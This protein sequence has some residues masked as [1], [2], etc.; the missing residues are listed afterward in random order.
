MVNFFSLVKHHKPVFMG[1]V[2]ITPD[3]FS[4]G[5]LLTQQDNI[6]HHIDALLQAGTNI[7][8]IGAESTRPNS[9]PIDADT[10]IQ[11]LSILNLPLRQSETCY[12]SIDTYKAQT[13]EFALKNGFHIVNDVTGL[14]YDPDMVKVVADYQAG[15]IIMHNQSRIINSTGNIV[16]D[17]YN[18][19]SQSLE[20]ALGHHIAESKICLD[21]GIGFGVTPQQ[22]IELLN[23]ISKFKSLGFPIMV[24][25][26]RKSFIKH[27]LHIDNPQKRLGATIATH[28]YACQQGADIIRVHDVDDH[29][30]FF[31]MLKICNHSSHELCDVG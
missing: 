21:I 31:D 26:S 10:E 20:I 30:Q 28:Y 24:G 2:N 27:Y 17:V 16:T 8:D 22:N 25:A 13:A 29:K 11:R 4:D 3:S 19:L 9:I 18:G 7:I 14:K 15:I 5:G 1:I 23:N 12:Y 6:Y